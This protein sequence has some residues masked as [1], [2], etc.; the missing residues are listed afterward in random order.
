MKEIKEIMCDLKVPVLSMK[1][2]GLELE[3]EENGSTF[4]EN[5]V[6][7]AKAVAAAINCGT[8]S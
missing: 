7:K 2:A 1:E 6:I 3:I 4:E 5:A 8:G